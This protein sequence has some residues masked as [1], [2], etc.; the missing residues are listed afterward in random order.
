MG[1]DYEFFYESLTDKE[2]TILEAYIML[3]FYK[4][5]QPLLNVVVPCLGEEIETYRQSYFYEKDIDKFLS[6]Y[7]N[8]DQSTI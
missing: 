2:A 3:K 4:E 1:I 5:K 8:I 7:M 6:F